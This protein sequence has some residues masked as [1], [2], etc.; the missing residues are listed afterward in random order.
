MIRKLINFLKF[1]EQERLKAQIFCG[2]SF[3]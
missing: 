1:M 2:R 3:F